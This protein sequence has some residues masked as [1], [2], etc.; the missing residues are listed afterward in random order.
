MH[1]AF[2]GLD[3]GNNQTKL[4]YWVK[5]ANGQREIKEQV[6]ISRVCADDTGPVSSLGAS[7]CE[8]Y[9]YQLS[10]ILY[11]VYAN[12]TY[13]KDP[14]DLLSQGRANGLPIRALAYAALQKAGFSGKYIHFMSNLPVQDFINTKGLGK[15]TF[16]EE[17]INA[18]VDLLKGSVT[19]QSLNGLDLPKM[20]KG[21]IYGEGVAA[22]V[23]F[24]FDNEGRERN[25][26]QGKRGK[27]FVLD[28]GGGTL[29]GA[30]VNHDFDIA[31]PKTE[32]LGT[33]KLYRI[34]ER[35]IKSVHPEI[36]NRYIDPID[37]HIL[38]QWVLSGTAQIVHFANAQTFDIQEQVA[39]GC[40]E[41]AKQI[42]QKF[43]PTQYHVDGTLLVG[44]GSNLLKDYL[45]K[46][47]N[48]YC[49]EH[50]EFAN[51][52]GF[53]KIATFFGD[54]SDGFKEDI[55]DCVPSEPRQEEALEAKA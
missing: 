53:L 3:I 32:K 45:P 54:K 55:L 50:P 19:D 27:L 51:A 21:S 20:L 17:M 48:V 24:Y 15:S 37:I 26:Y 4:A 42:T 9:T 25:T 13:G 31:D 29:D 11:T 1:A 43:D 16:N 49:P 14:I 30:V 28:P 40:K 41:L 38:E 10:G 6:L 33:M 44:G 36:A 12:A 2:V 8:S 39:E 52:R 47:W 23:D 22:Y 46:E 34:I 18:K 35:M 7:S 5:N